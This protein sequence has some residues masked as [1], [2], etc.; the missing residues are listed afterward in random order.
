MS[1]DYLSHKAGD[2]DV[3]QLNRPVPQVA[4]VA[5]VTM[6]QA[7]MALLQAGKYAAAEAAIAALPEPQRQAAQL[8]WEFKTVVSRDGQLLNAIA[9]ALGL[10]PSQVDDLF[11]AA[12]AIPPV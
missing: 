8:A 1:D 5:T 12:T 7:R 9:A 6:Y 3:V 2:A 4:F 11:A 10:S